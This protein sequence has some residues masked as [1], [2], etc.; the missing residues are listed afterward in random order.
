MTGADG[1]T[2]D[3]LRHHVLGSILSRIGSCKSM[4]GA[5]GTMASGRGL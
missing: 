5:L 2:D 4:H 3:V 1:Q